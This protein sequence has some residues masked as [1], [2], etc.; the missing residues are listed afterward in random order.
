MKE[1]L[2]DSCPMNTGIYKRKSKK[3]LKGEKKA[4]KSNAI[5]FF[6]IPL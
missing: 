4:V 2:S 6:F 1:F 3:P 5:C